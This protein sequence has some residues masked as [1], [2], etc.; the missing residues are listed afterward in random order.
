ME[1]VLLLLALAA[2]PLVMWLMMRSMGGKGGKRDDPAD[3]HEATHL[4]G[5]I[6]ALREEVARRKAEESL[7]PS[8]SSDRGASE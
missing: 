3:R 5:E 8:R 1:N 4:K 2:C 6:A 7:D